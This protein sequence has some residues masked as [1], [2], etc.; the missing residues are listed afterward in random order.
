MSGVKIWSL[1]YS[2]C[3]GMDYI[4]NLRV[5]FNNNEKRE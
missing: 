3:G 5:L 1:F 4:N 2:D